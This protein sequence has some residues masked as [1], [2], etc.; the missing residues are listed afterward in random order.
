MAGK[1]FYAKGSG[2]HIAYEAIGSGAR[3]ILVVMEG[4]ISI[5][6]MDDESRMSHAMARPDSFGRLIRF[7]RRGI[8]L[9]DPVT[10]HDPPTL[11]QWVDDA[12]AVLDEV[13]SHRAVVV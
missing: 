2:A 1:V 9:S 4:F 11:E 12:I 6:M 5:D 10:P 8:G 13:G 3:D 7:D